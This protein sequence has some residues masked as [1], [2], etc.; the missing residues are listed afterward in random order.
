MT[1]LE[2]MACN[3][4]IPVVL[5]VGW[6]ALLYAHQGNVDRM[7]ATIGNFAVCTFACLSGWVVVEIIRA[8]VA[9]F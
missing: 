7:N 3:L 9:E 5:L 1:F 2:R 4:L 8:L 6:L